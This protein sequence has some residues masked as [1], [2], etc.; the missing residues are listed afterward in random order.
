SALSLLHRK[1]IKV[2]GEISIIGYD[3]TRAAEMAFPPL[4]TM[5]QPLYQMGK[6]AVDIVLGHRSAE[7]LLL[8]HQM[9]ERET[10]GQR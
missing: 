10:V 1:G 9:V 7:S 3:N 2:P 5:A 8:S 4:T 6:K